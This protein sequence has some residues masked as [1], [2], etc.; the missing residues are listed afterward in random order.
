MEPDLDVALVVE[1]HVGED[2]DD[3][4]EHVRV[5]TVAVYH[6]HVQ[7][8]VNQVQV[9]HL[10]QHVEVIRGTCHRRQGLEAPE[11]ALSY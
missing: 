1:R 5:A 2:C 10:N 11:D 6:E 9:T 7:Q 3:R 8:D 4:A